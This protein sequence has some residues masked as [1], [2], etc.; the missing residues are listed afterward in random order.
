MSD[1]PAGDVAS[2]NIFICFL[3]C[4]RGG[5][6]VEDAVYTAR[7]GH[8]W[9]L[10]AVR[11]AAYSA[12]AAVGKDAMHF[13][14]PGEMNDHKVTP[15]PHSESLPPT[16]PSFNSAEVAYLAFLGHPEPYA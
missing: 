9:D 7:L 1:I 3:F 4:R 8:G 10:Q 12:L 14:P 2:V 16:R 6:W 5:A 13:R 15:N 11:E